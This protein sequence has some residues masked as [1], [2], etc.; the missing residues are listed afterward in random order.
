MTWLDRLKKPT[1]PQTNV[2]SALDHKV[3]R[4]YR[5][6]LYLY[7]LLRVTKEWKILKDATD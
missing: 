1:D 5:E 4:W 2:V 3:Q 7:V 6:S